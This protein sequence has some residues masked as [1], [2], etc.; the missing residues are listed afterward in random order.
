VPSLQ[1]TLLGKVPEASLDY[2]IGLWE[3]EP[4][5]F[6]LSKTRSSK[7][8]DYRYDPKTK[9][10]QVTVNE[11]LNPYQFLITYIH[12]VAH[13][14]VH[15]P[16]G[17]LKPHGAHWK[18]EFR[19]LLL[20]LMNDQVFPDDVL[21]PL[22]RHMKNPKASTA[23]DPLLFQAISTY[24]LENDGVRIINLKVGESFLLRSRQF[25]LI[26]K[27]RTRALCLDLGNRKR[28]L[29]PMIAEVSPL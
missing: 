18:H 12:E 20:P 9:S 3:E 7:L 28:Y 27:K 25:Q 8:G 4:F 26:E 11:D 1:Q 21:R 19:R 10:H 23:G 29:I 13:R 24:N 15:Q 2:C 22:A 16:K 6:K 14:R 5:R 17:R